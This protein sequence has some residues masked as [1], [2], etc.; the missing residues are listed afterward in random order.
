M[1]KT[2][3]KRGNRPLEAAREVAGEVAAEVA[4]IE[5]MMGPATVGLFDP[6]IIQPE[7]RDV[8]VRIY[9][10]DDRLKKLVFHGYLNFEEA[11]EA[12][13]AEMFGGGNY[14]AQV[15]AADDEVPSGAVRKWA[16]ATIPGPYRNPEGVAGLAK[17]SPAGKAPAMVRV[18]GGEVS[19]LPTANESLN[20]ALVGSV[21]DL[22]KAQREIPAV[23]QSS[24][25]EWAPIITP[26]VGGIVT[27]L[28]AMLERKPDPTLLRLQEELREMRD[29]PG[30]ATTAVTDALQGIE[31]IVKLTRN[32]KQLA[33]E[34]A[35]VP[36]DP[37]AAMWGM[38]GKLL[39]HLGG[40]KAE[41]PK[42]NPSPMLTPGPVAPPSPP[43]PLWQQTLLGNKGRLVDS[44][45]RGVS[46][47][48]V[49]DIAVQFAPPQAMGV[50]TEF[51]QRPDMVALAMQTIPE[52]QQFPAWTEQFFQALK[53]AVLGDG[54]DEADDTPEG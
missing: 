54:S 27:L 13:L 19:T 37:E 23:A 5:P 36:A 26:V 48:F 15:I 32:V 43:L 40:P 17:G 35:D 41:T 8:R 22:L 50:L 45:M 52:L 44:A 20:A 46:P 51:V 34:D 25:K 9:R 10:E 11:T 14:V 2:A 3:R 49:A 16:R 38:A 39:E 42:L 28:T 47:E 24:V 1:G 30:P 12:L 4:A 33:A 21:I 6:A 18:A 53:A 7:W 31:R 29:R